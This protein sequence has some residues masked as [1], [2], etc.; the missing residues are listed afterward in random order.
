MS[1]TNFD[2]TIC[3]CILHLLFTLRCFLIP[4]LHL[5]C[6]C[7][8]FPND[9]RNPKVLVIFTSLL[10]F[11][12][13]RLEYSLSVQNL[14]GCCYNHPHSYKSLKFSPIHES[15]VHR[16]PFIAN[17]SLFRTVHAKLPRSL[18]I[19]NEARA[20]SAAVNFSGITRPGTDK[21]GSKL[22]RPQTT[23][24][25]NNVLDF[26]SATPQTRPRNEGGIYGG[27]CPLRKTTC[28]MFAALIAVLY[29][30]DG[31]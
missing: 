9:L 24:N 25:L 1:S 10:I 23:R 2:F 20:P 27:V 22:T 7:W 15:N 17:V 11:Y 16:S 28:P 30:G 29:K 14:L 26:W 6:L 21:R 19:T 5:C 3:L 4:E 31:V 12:R 13:F 18:I 8:T